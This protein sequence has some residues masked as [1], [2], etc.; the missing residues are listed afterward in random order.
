[1]PSHVR[2][3]LSLGAALAALLGSGAPPVL[4]Q[5]AAGVGTIEG[6]VR[7]GRTNRPVEGAQISVSGTTIGAVA[8]A[9]GTFRIPNVPARAVELRARF[10]GFAP[11][12]RSA[13]VVAGQTVTV[14]FN[15]QPSALQ[16]DEVV[17][18]GTGGQVE[19]RKLGNTVAT[20]QPPQFAPINSPSDLLQG[21]EPGVVGL[22]SGGMTG[23]GARIRIRGN[24]SISMSNEPIVF[25]DGLRVDNSGGFSTN[26]DAGLGGSPSRLDDLDP[27]SIERIEILKGAAAATLYGT[28][29]SNGV[30]Q[31]FTKRGAAG[32]PRWTFTAQQDAITH[33]GDRVKPN[34]GFAR[35]QAVADR[36]ERLYGIADGL[37]P[38]QVVEVDMSDEIWQTGTATTLNGQ[39]TGGNQALTYFLSGRYAT[40]DG[41]ITAN[42]WGPAEDVNRLTTAT[43]NLSAFPVPSLKIGARAGYTN[44]RMAAV[45]NNN[46]IYGTTALAM[47]GKPEHGECN[48]TAGLLG[49]TPATDPGAGIAGF[50]RCKAIP[51]AVNPGGQGPGNI[52]G[53]RAFM[54]VRESFGGETVQQVDRVTGVFDA[55]Y[56]PITSLSFAGLVGVDYAGTQNTNFREFGYAIDNFTGNDPEG[57]RLVEDRNNREITLDGKGNWNTNFSPRLSS[58]FVAGA[59]WFFSRSQQPGVQNSQFPGPGFE[60]VTAGP[61]PVPYER[62]L[63]TVNGGYFAQEQVGFDNWVFATVGARYDFSSAFGETSEGILYPKF[64]LSVVPSDLPRWV[65]LGPVSTLRLRGAIGQSGRQPG[66]FD[67]LTTFEPLPGEEGSGFAPFNLG[68]PNLK[69]EISTEWELGGEAGLF[70]DRLSF[71][72]TYWNRTV[73]DLL[74]AKQFPLSGGFRGLQLANVGEMTANGFEIGVKGFAFNRPNA[75]LDLFANAAYIEQLV[76]SLGGAAPIK[77]GGAYPRYRNF[78]K[79]GEA[80]GALFG[81]KLVQPCRGGETYTCLQPGQ[82]PFDLDN[83]RVPDTE[84]QMLAYLASPRDP[85]VLNPMRV[86]EDLDGDY[87]DH[88]LG[89]PYPDWT[90]SFGGTLTFFNRW[91]LYSL[92]EYKAG[93]Y[94]ITNLTDAFRFANPTIGRNTR[95]VAE[96]EATLLNP[97]ST[98]QQ[99]LDAAMLWANKYKA[100]SPYDGLNQNE[101]GDFMR[102]RELSLTFTSSPDFAARVGARDLSV[103]FSGRNLMLWTKY[104]GVDPELNYQSR[105]GAPFD[106]QNAVDNNFGDA[107]DAF[108]FPIPRRFSL[109]VRLGY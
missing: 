78:I 90:G 94:T 18:T 89:K 20:I 43:V 38:Y 87:L 4:A 2:R 98:A 59:Q 58:S 10:V 14:D 83:D 84:A 51:N 47:F 79:E 92:F 52:F 56:T 49:E 74:V 99:R 91:R 34:A 71:D 62:I 36:M 1:M 29:A 16:L 50:M 25:V 70:E 108:A 27:S 68:N 73:S 75:S 107:I 41:P 72:V 93:N 104:S 53:N 9:N 66:A 46:N 42:G 95:A 100:L 40:E 60:V 96:V 97:T 82:L 101:P 22:P 31:I 39:V 37:T 67:K 21:R 35:T 17:T 85:G 11:T 55:T 12:T 5:E 57:F 76:T 8:G 19:V 64:S 33:P 86:D 15:L 109:S 32:A 7:E 48:V 24:A 65:G 45:Q 88:Y 61:N 80:P 26:V 54:T 30:I 77:V 44:R 23:D 102:W 3:I 6:T 105:T 69:P 81:A 63:S 106:N 13:T 103:T 28:E